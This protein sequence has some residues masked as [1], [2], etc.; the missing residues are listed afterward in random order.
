MIASK[1]LSVREI[2]E[3]FGVTT[4]GIYKWIREGRFPPPQKIGRLSRWPR[5]VLRHQP[6]PRR[7]PKAAHPMHA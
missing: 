4:Q 7:N 1:L 5:S 6:P 3:H 2:A